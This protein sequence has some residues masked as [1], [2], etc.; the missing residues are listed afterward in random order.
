MYIIGLGNPGKQYALTRHNIGWMV[1]DRLRGE[2]QCADLVDKRIWKAKVCD[3]RTDKDVVFSVIYP[4]T[5][6]NKSGET[7]RA[8]YH[9]DKNASLVLVHDD[10]ALPL[11][12]VRIVQGR[13]AG[14]HNGVTSVYRE[15]KRDDIIRVRIGV[16]GRRWW[17]ETTH[18]PSG[19]ELS[20]FV[21]SRFSLWERSVLDSGISNGVGALSTILNSGV[22]AA[23]NEWNA[24]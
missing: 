21:L 23:M 16:A 24:K 12:V 8:I 20:R 10:I 14:G 17:N 1:L 13:G 9:D 15:T 4:Q 6:M 3:C 7:A 22:T 19:A 18:V 2:Y 11:G 5:F